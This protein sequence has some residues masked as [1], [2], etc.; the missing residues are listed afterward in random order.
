MTLSKEIRS[1]FLVS[2]FHFSIFWIVLCAFAPLLKFISKF[3]SVTL[4]LLLILPLFILYFWIIVTPLPNYN[5]FKELLSKYSFLTTLLF[6]TYDKHI[7]TH[8][9]TC[10]YLNFSSP[11]WTDVFPYQWEIFWWWWNRFFYQQWILCFWILAAQI[12]SFSLA[13]CTRKPN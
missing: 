4:V 13:C 5:T 8:A 7:K 6:C 2:L 3:S 10:K 12:N 9:N 11:I 1:S